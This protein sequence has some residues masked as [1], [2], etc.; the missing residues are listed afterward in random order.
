MTENFAYLFK[1]LEKEELPIDKSEFSFQVQSHPDYPTLLSI[2]DTLNFFSIENFAAPVGFEQI[3]MLPDSFIAVLKDDNGKNA[4]YFIEK[5]QASFLS[6]KGKK[7]VEY[8]RTQLQQRWGGIVLLAEKPAEIESASKN[9]YS[10][11]LP[12]LSLILLGIL[13]YDAGGSLSGKIFI[14]FPI[15]GLL[16]SIAALKDLFGAKSALIARFCNIS[17]D[18]SCETILNS[19]KWKL[20]QFLNFSSLSIVFFAAQFIS[21]FVFMLAG[22]PNDYF[23]IQ[24]A[25]LL[26]SLP[27]IALSL[28]YQKMVEKK[29]CPI[30]LA[31]IAALLAEL[32]YI[33]TV[34][35]SPSAVSARS[36]LLSALLFSVTAFIWPLLKQMLAE[37]NDL[38]EKN[39][40]AARFIRNYKLFKIVLQSKPRLD[41][42]QGSIQLGNPDSSIEITIITNPFCGY[43]KDADALLGRILKLHGEKLKIN[44]L[45]GI[46]IEKE[47]D[48][49]KLLLR[50]L[51]AIYLENGEK[52][53]SEALANWFEEKNIN[54][55]L[56]QYKMDFDIS[57]IDALFARQSAW[58]RN[59]HFQLTPTL[60]INGYHYPKVYDRQN[61][62][63]FIN[64]LIEDD[65]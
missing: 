17:A 51:M 56:Q 20:F 9:N 22:S 50:S 29:W 65:F 53:Y 25:L 49:K 55:W 31:I 6:Y 39:F 21:L 40:K 24:K 18:A 47:A 38:Q 1:Y 19:N 64:E 37:R 11:L 32:L 26:C 60:F 44:V 42:L 41:V 54:G 14:I 33:E 10:L 4:P 52:A 62:E 35:E 15:I 45:M 13:Y 58:C 28:Y 48:E 8:D 46:D 3:E 5:K 12:A 27:A 43:C 59:N 23:I 7:P 30:C 36:V 34:F 2:S 61:L 16:F 57:K 63:Y